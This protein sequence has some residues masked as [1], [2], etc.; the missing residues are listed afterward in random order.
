[1]IQGRAGEEQGKNNMWEDRLERLEKNRSEHQKAGGRE[2]IER[3]HARGKMT[4]MERIEY[5]LD[6]GS[7]RELYACRKTD[8]SA[9]ALGARGIYPGDGVITGWGKINSRSVLVAADDFTVIGGTMGT[10][11]AKKILALQDLALKRGV[12]VIFL[13]DS[14]GARVEEGINA[15]TGYGEM[16]R[17]HVRASGRILQICAIMGP[18]SGGACY[19]PALCD[20]IFCVKNTSN[21]FITGPDVVEAVL[22]RRP[23]IETLGGAVMHATH[24]G[25]AHALYDDDR[26][27]LDGIRTLLDYLPSNCDEPARELTRS[28]AADIADIRGASIPAG[29]GM[30]VQSG[31][32]APGQSSFT[33]SVSGE[34]GAAGNP[35]GTYAG[36]TD[37]AAPSTGKGILDGILSGSMPDPLLQEEL[38]E[39]I[40]HR[41]IPRESLMKIVPDNSRQAYNMHDLIMAI[42]DYMPFFEIQKHFATNAIVGFGW[43]HGRVTGVIANQPMSMGGSLDVDASDKIA[44]FIRFC[45]CFHI[46]LL[47]LVDVPAFLP[48]VDQERKGIIR[49]GAKIIY[50]Y[51]EATVPKVTLIVRK[52]YGGAYIAMNSRSLGADMVFAWPIAEIAVMGAEG[53]IHILH[54]KELAQSADPDADIKRWTEEYEDVFANPDIAEDQGFV[55]DVIFP[56][57]TR[58][59]LIT[60]FDLLGGNLKTGYVHGNIPM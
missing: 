6:K 7:F 10:V 8:E 57:E 16:F 50:A 56:E 39:R 42:L 28:L 2:R 14:G 44:R 30:A 37:S 24:S 25:V 34:A 18:C 52:A 27:C 26:S 20:F 12:P 15:L 55:D 22:G 9:S 43:L 3:Q 5:L 29:P 17:R 32:S 38:A 31:F 59:R 36:R 23:D 51:S 48:G 40:G 1:M 35:A 45:D 13:N 49:H 54:R 19:S 60:A 21:M 11:H 33:K 4:A 47:T 58:D 41:V 46:Q 53:A